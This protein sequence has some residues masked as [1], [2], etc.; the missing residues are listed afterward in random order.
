M[1]NG[2]MRLQKSGQYKKKLLEL[3]FTFKQAQY[4]T[5]E[6]AYWKEAFIVM[7]NSFYQYRTLSP[8]PSTPDPADLT[9]TRPQ[10]FRRFPELPMELRRRVWDLVAQPNSNDVEIYYNQDLRRRTVSKHRQRELC[11]LLFACKESRDVVRNIYRMVC[12]QDLVVEPSYADAKVLLHTN[13]NLFINLREGGA[14]AIFRHQQRGVI[15]NIAGIA[16]RWEYITRGQYN[17]TEDIKNWLLRTDGPKRV[18]RVKVWKGKEELDG[19]PYK[20][21]SLAPPQIFKLQ[22]DPRRSQNLQYSIEEQHALAEF[23]G[24]CVHSKK[25]N[26]PKLLSQELRSTKEWVSLH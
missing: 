10:V 4:D 9:M 6:L 1:N 12:L 11:P 21:I 24:E 18:K 2:E 14:E 25:I 17:I 26:P 16:L 5:P 13:D 15:S 20:L 7:L 3:I 8:S 22:S 23:E 19:H